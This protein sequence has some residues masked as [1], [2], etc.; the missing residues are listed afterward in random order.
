MCGRH[1]AQRPQEDKTGLGAQ[2]HGIGNPI[3]GEEGDENAAT[4]K[5][6]RQGPVPDDADRRQPDHRPN[7]N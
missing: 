1:Q 4:P 5:A 7:L 6:L 3:I 2:S